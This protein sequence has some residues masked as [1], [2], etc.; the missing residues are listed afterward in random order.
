[1]KFQLKPITF[2][3]LSVQNLKNHNL[4]MNSSRGYLGD[5]VKLGEQCYHC[6]I[7]LPKPQNVLHTRLVLG[8][9]LANNVSPASQKR[10]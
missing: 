10:K 1:M 7:P 2:M 4:T 6:H 5:T 9:P 8:T 3:D